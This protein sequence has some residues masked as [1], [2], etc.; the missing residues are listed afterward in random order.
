MAAPAR[1][2]I[3]WLIAISLALSLVGGLD[4]GRASSSDEVGVA[5]VLPGGARLATT[6]GR[7]GPIRV[8]EGTALGFD[9]RSGKWLQ[10]TTVCD[11]SA[12]IHEDDVVVAPR[13]SGLT[14]GVGF[15]IAEAVVVVDAGHGGDR[16]PGAVGP[17]GLVESIV[18]LDVAERLR[19]LLL[20][21]HDV[22][23]ETGEVSPGERV[24]A[25]G[26]VFM[27]RMYD[28]PLDGDHEAGLVYRS[29]LANGAGAHA[30][31]SIHNNGG[32]TVP[33][34]QPGSEVYYSTAAAGSDRLGSLIHQEML[35]SFS[36]FKAKWSGGTVV[37]AQARIST[38]TGAD[39]YGVLRRARGPAVI[40]EG[41]YITRP[42]EESLLAS[43]DFR[44]AYAEGVYRG[45]VR[46]L[47]TSESGSRIHAPV[48]FTGGTVANHAGCVIPT[49]AD[50]NAGGEAREERARRQKRRATLAAEGGSP[51]LR[52]PAVL[53][54]FLAAL[55]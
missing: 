3:V 5:S 1:W 8:A 36:A 13:A 38:R 23:W 4:A 42:A 20:A 11:T 19:A 15:P 31:V 44:Q 2:S 22:D 25:V 54:R 37:G 17:K 7:R 10:V 12:W 51:G 53:R 47:S 21:S 41:L 52:A 49:Q 55:G 32:P 6:P 14:P 45:I 29:A 46:F 27:T 28:G 18:N 48:T 30:F 34:S 26:T 43:G 50:L 9:K 35:R 39:Y 40:A 24:A 33:L 16:D